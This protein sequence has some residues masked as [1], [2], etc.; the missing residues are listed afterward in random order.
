MMLKSEQG[1][2][3]KGRL[4]NRW[5]RIIVPVVRLLHTAYAGPVQYVVLIP[6]GQERVNCCWRRL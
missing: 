1:G 5:D 2:L 3:M 4:G 6:L